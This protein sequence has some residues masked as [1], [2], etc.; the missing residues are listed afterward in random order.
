M[1]AAASARRRGSHHISEMEGFSMTMSAPERGRAAFLFAVLAALLVSFAAIRP[2]HAVPSFARK[3]ETSCITCH[4]IYPVLNPF[5]EAFRR[6]GYRFPSQNGSVDSDA[7]KAEVVALGQE[8]YKK[9]FPD[10]VWPDSVTKAVPLSAMMNGQVAVNIPGS[11]AHEAAGNTFTWGGLSG[12]FHL[13]GAGSFD[14]KVTYF[15]QLTIPD[16]GSIEIETAYVLW[17]D[18]VGPRHLLNLWLGRLMSPQIT[19]FGLHSSYLGDSFLPAVSVA[20]LYSP[21]ASFTL[22]QGHSDGIEANGIIDHR[23]GWSVGWIA[24]SVGSGLSLPNAEDLYAHVGVKTGGVALDGEGR[25]GPNAPDPAKPWAEKALTFD[26]FA[27]RGLSLIDNGTGT[28]AGGTAAPVSQRDTFYA[29]GGALRAQWDSLVLNSGLQFEHHKRPYPGAPATA[30]AAG[31]VTPGAVTEGAGEAIVQY[32]EL[33]YIVFPWLVPGV[34]TEYT[35]I[36]LPDGDH[37]GLL[38]VMPGVATLVRPNIKVVVTGDFETAKGLT[39]PSG[40]WSAAGGATTKS[41]FEAEQI[42]LSAAVAF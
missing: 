5:G 16:D 6:N 26:A 12:E 10:A 2:A 9:Q 33:D 13:F 28:V 35:R 21:G 39:P 36:S 42:L 32:N 20:G 23:V 17:N 3:Y 25:Y 31:N 22:G 24:S 11:D 38:R 29:V 27:Y 18:V 37:A 41:T 8:E 15:S 30:D 14:D 1:R 19:S 34:R 4:T 40:D 7:A